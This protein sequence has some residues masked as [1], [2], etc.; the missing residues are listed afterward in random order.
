MNS[1]SN[2][3]NNNNF[4]DIYIPR[5]DA[6][7]SE[8]D[9]KRIFFNIA[10]ISHVDFVAV[11]SPDKIIQFYSAFLKVLAWNTNSLQFTQIS[12]SINNSARITITSTEFWIILKAKNPSVPRTKVNI[13]QLV[14][15][16]DEL[17]TKLHTLTD[18]TAKLTDLYTKQTLQI[19]QQALQ[20]NTL[21]EMVAKQS[22]DIQQLRANTNT[23]TNATN[24]NATNANTTNTN[25]T[26]T[27]ATNTN[28]TTNANNDYD[29]DE[30]E[31]EEEHQVYECDICN[32]QFDDPK[33]LNFHEYA[34][35]PRYNNN[36]PNK[37]LTPHA[38]HFD[39]PLQ[40]FTNTHIR[41]INS[42]RF[43]GNA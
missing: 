31:D 12:T 35:K 1:N 34:C 29:Q 15:Y 19:N 30:Y 2:S 36:K 14:A 6:R 22:Q 41:A 26:N 18:E 9:V 20:I 5:I 42:H 23:N 33:H 21:M 11:K 27:N 39:V 4:S 37:T 10:N 28:A 3:N 8:D 13:H 24:T 7:Y 25:A 38:T 17:F 40:Q 32:L 43:C 16:S